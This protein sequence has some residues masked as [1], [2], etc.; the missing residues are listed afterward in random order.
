MPLYLFP[1]DLSIIVLREGLKKH[2]FFSEKCKVLSRLIPWLIP[3]N[4]INLRYKVQ[5]LLVDNSRHVQGGDMAQLVAYLFGFIKLQYQATSSQ[6]MEYRGIL[7]PRWEKTS[8]ILNCLCHTMMNQN[9]FNK[10][11]WWSFFIWRGNS[12]WNLNSCE[13]SFLPLFT[14]VLQ[15]IGSMRF[16]QKRT[17]LACCRNFLGGHVYL[18]SCCHFMGRFRHQRANME[19]LMEVMI[20]EKDVNYWNVVPK[21]TILYVL[22]IDLVFFETMYSSLFSLENGSFHLHLKPLR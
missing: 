12:D 6:G 21:A 18:K 7:R 16:L 1:F 10:W 9:G 19:L 3:W 20:R 2:V 4:T 17:I 22:V 5:L 15:S 8:W 13:D 11:G 14:P